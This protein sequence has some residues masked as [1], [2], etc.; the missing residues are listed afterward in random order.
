MRTEAAVMRRVVTLRIGGER[1]GVGVGKERAREEKFEKVAI[2]I[3]EREKERNPSLV[4]QI[5]SLFP[6]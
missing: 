5:L 1:W 6:L 4:I 2:A 3:R